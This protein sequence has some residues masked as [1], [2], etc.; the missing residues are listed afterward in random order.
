M[1]LHLDCRC[2]CD[3]LKVEKFN[4][5]LGI[6]SFMMFKSSAMGFWQRVKQSWRYFRDG[7]FAYN[8]MIFEK[9]DLDKL[10][11]FLVHARDEKEAKND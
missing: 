1:K 7:E 9:A 5:D 3:V 10:I 2:G 11:D 6:F 8:D 4:D